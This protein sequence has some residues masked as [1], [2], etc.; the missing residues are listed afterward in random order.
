M[1]WTLFSWQAKLPAKL[2]QFLFDA[3]PHARCV[4]CI[5]CNDAQA[6]PH[7]LR[8][9]FLQ[10]SL[11]TYIHIC[12]LIWLLQPL[13]QNYDLAFHTTHVVWIIFTMSG[14]TYSLTTDFWET[15]HEQFYFFLRIFARILLKGSNRRNIFSYFVLLEI[16]DLDFEPWPYV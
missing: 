7:L 12:V 8:F 13:S 2:S 4:Q 15:F 14:R 3:N 10:I 16:S 1:V 11:N 9:H 5:Q 6:W